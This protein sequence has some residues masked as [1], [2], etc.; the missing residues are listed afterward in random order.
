MAGFADEGWERAAGLNRG[1]QPQEQVFVQ[2]SLQPTQNKTKSAEAGRPIFDE[3][4]YVQ[5]MVPGDKQNVI[6]RPVSEKDRQ[7]F[8]RQYEAWKESGQQP[9]SG[10]P[11]DQW[12]A[13][14]RAQ[15]AELAYFN[16]KTVEQLASMSDGNAMGIG[17]IT[18]LRQ[19]AKDFVA[20]AAGNAPLQQLR[21]QLAERDNEIEVLKR[22]VAELAASVKKSRKKESDE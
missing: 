10:T 6:H 14:T 20:A 4:E 22:Q 13:V 12:P 18:S 7:R 8:K 5:I 9:V 15:V 16:V 3:L 21:D 17:P 2:F 19:K 11:L 1:Q